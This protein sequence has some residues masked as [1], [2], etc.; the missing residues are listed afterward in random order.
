MTL[1]P[2][3]SPH[4]LFLTYVLYSYSD[5]KLWSVPDRL[6]ARF[7][8][9]QFCANL[10]S[11]AEFHETVARL[12][13]AL[14]CATEILIN[15]TQRLDRVL[16][17]PGSYHWSREETLI[18]LAGY[19]NGC[20]EDVVRLLPHRSYKSFQHRIAQVRKELEK[21][22]EKRAWKNN[23]PRILINLALSYRR[24]GAKDEATKIYS[25][26]QTA[27]HEEAALESLYPVDVLKKIF[28]GVSTTKT[29]PLV[30]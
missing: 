12:G 18:L 23:V 30:S 14:T 10:I 16:Y 22:K 24:D 5:F 9:E 17:C 4:Q 6:R 7:L 28:G 1:V 3:D 27:I 2:P 15:A 11:P 29:P 13:T 26:F 19:A 20:L 25:A 21:A 8:F